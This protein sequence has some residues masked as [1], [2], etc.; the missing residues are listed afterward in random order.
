MMP[1]APL[2]GKSGKNEIL[3]LIIIYKYKANTNANKQVYH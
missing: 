1:I 2:C 3:L